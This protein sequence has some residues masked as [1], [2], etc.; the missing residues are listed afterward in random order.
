MAVQP[1][2]AASTLHVSI[3]TVFFPFLEPLETNKKKQ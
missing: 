2:V 3:I 1:N